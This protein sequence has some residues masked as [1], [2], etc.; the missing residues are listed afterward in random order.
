MLLALDEEVSRIF[1]VAHVAEPYRFGE[2]LPQRRLGRCN[3]KKKKEA[4]SRAMEHGS[5]EERMAERR[6][7]AKSMRTMRNWSPRSGVVPTPI[8]K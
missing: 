8:P 7:L 2:N 5:N 6:D 1:A 4:Y 3:Q